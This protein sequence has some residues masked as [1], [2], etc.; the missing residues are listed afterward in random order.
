MSCSNYVVKTF[1]HVAGLLGLSAVGTQ[2][3]V[4]DPALTYIKEKGG[5]LGGLLFLVAFLGLFWLFL[6]MQPGPLKYIAAVGFSLFFGMLLRGK[7]F[8]LQMKDKLT[9]VLV[10]TTAISVG[11]VG[12]ALFDKS[13]RF[14]NMLPIL[15]VGLLGIIAVSMYYYIMH[16]KKPQWLS[17][18]G[19]VLFTF[20]IG[21]DTQLIREH[22]KMCRTGGADY[23]D[24][25]FGL[26]LDILNLFSKLA[27]VE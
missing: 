14:M 9:E 4:A 15:F 12:L 13:G 17:I 5:L 22:A 23:I 26:Y 25:A 11:M 19:A 20:F 3:G 21:A 16:E 18:A 2:L 10:Y 6:M 24:E 27:D 1:A 8:N 7:I